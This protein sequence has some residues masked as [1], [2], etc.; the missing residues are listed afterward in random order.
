MT[1]YFPVGF[2]FAAELTYPE[3]EGTSSG[4]L[5]ASAQ[6]FTL[7][8]IVIIIII[9]FVPSVVKIPRLKS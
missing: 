6:V 7:N 5:N 4:L 1:G 9:F 8:S 3:S 2:E